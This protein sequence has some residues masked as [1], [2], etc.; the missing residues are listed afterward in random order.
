MVDIVTKILL[1]SDL[2]S[3]LEALQSPCMSLL[4]NKENVQ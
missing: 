1:R 2:G 3:D 4:V